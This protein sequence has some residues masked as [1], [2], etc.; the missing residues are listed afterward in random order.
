MSSPLMSIHRRARIESHE[1]I[2]VIHGENPR[3]SRYTMQ[4]TD[5]QLI[6]RITDNK[7]VGTSKSSSSVNINTQDRETELRE[8]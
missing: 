2:N 7:D 5:D 1:N 4:Q 8:H 6:S 3:E